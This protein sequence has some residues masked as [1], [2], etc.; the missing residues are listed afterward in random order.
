M[1]SIRLGKLWKTSEKHSC[2]NHR[3]SPVN[4]ARPIELIYF[5]VLFLLILNTLTLMR[6]ASK[7]NFLSLFH[8]WSEQ[9]SSLSR[10]FSDV[11]LSKRKLLF[12]L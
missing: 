1:M 2:W 8:L 11:P 3:A 9:K 10:F 6:A 4:F 5:L 12:E 7:C